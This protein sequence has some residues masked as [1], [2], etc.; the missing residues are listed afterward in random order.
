VDEALFYIWD[1]IGV[2]EAIS[3]RDEYSRYVPAV[4]ALLKSSADVQKIAAYLT[5]VQ[6]EKMGMHSND[7]L[8]LS[9]A[10]HLFELNQWLLS[11]WPL[12]CARRDPA[13]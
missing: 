9:T 3:T 7:A 10:E 4:V 6:T 13:P 12:A 1:P 8:S 11:Q 5:S 2:V